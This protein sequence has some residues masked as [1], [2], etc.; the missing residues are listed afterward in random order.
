MLFVTIKLET[1]DVTEI[2]TGKQEAKKRANSKVKSKRSAPNIKYF[3]NLVIL[4]KMEILEKKTVKKSIFKRKF[5]E[6]IFQ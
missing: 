1:K 6:S 5:L 3:I 4:K 2:T